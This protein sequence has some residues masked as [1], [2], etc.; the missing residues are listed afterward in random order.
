MEVSYRLDRAGIEEI[1]EIWDPESLVATGD[2]GRLR[3]VGE[4][5]LLGAPALRT[6]LAGVEGD[7]ELDCSGLTFI[8]SSG[9]AILE[10]TQRACKEK[11]VNFCLVDPSRCVMRLLDLVSLT[12]FFDIRDNSKS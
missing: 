6:L 5:D 11:G 9:L 1:R 12:G 8:D 2:G 10:E 7:I 3:L 4:L